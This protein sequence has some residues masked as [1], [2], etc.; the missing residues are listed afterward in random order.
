LVDLVVQLPSFGGEL[1][2]RIEEDVYYRMEYGDKAVRDF[3]E[4][5]VRRLDARP[6]NRRLLAYAAWVFDEDM[7][8]FERLAKSA[9]EVRRSPGVRLWVARLHKDATAL[10]A[11]AEDRDVFAEVRFDAVSTMVDLGLLSPER[12]AVQF[13]ELLKSVGYQAQFAEDYAAFLE[14]KGRRSDAIALLDTWLE[15]NTEHHDLADASVR[16]KQ[17]RF[18]A[19]EG[20]LEKAWNVL[21]PALASYKE[22]A[23]SE[24]ARLLVLRGETERA[25]ALGRACLE[26]YPGANAAA[27]LAFVLWRAGEPGEAAR[28]LTN[29][30]HQPFLT[31]EWRWKFGREFAAAFR[32]RPAPDAVAAIEALS[33]EGVDVQGDT[34]R[35]LLVG[36]GNA[37]EE[38]ALR[39]ELLVHLPPGPTPVFDVARL[40]SGYQAGREVWGA[41][42]AEAWLAA[43]IPSAEKPILALHAFREGEPVLLWTIVPWVDDE[44]NEVVERAWLFRQAAM[45]AG[46]DR[47]EGHARTL[48]EHFARPSSSYLH[49]LGRYLRGLETEESVLGLAAGTQHACA[50]AYYLGLRAHREG[51]YADASL[52]YRASVST[53]AMT[54]PEYTLAHHQLDNWRNSKLGLEQL[55]AN[56]L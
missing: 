17:A 10:G 47:D 44:T 53:G 14:E 4:R 2:E 55:R 19:D 12:S 36:M 27:A 48:R 46:T 30:P 15:W 9:L 13:E 41:A 32:G 40:L 29:H 42:P 3:S 8:R 34:L 56:K 54:T 5:L 25:K 6:D 38:S 37:R 49:Q 52:W 35:Q 28:V 50:V 43:Q 11:L 39:F 26:R 51:R 22:D 23:L 45:L 33:R 7:E 16:A 1:I 31:K 18:L 24:G 20:E 21:Q